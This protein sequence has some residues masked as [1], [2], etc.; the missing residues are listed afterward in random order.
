M[1][2]YSVMR[3]CDTKSSARAT[4]APERGMG[5]VNFEPEMWR[6]FHCWNLLMTKRVLMSPA[7]EALGFFPGC[8][9]LI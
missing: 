5:S 3:V 6:G 8:E 4:P 7:A 9:N 2:G 1:Y